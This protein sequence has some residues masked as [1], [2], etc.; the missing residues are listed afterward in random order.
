[1][2][3]SILVQ[4]GCRV[5]LQHVAKVI[6]QFA[7]LASGK[8]PYVTI[9]PSCSSGRT[10]VLDSLEANVLSQYIFF[11]FIT[12][13]S[14]IDQFLCGLGALSNLICPPVQ[15]CWTSGS[16]S[17]LNNILITNGL[18]NFVLLFTKN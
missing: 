5:E 1:M 16:T 17:I 2:T 8:Q 18:L 15:P 7:G 4:S 12:G 13:V 9:W 14:F 10:L 3:R 6:S 11:F